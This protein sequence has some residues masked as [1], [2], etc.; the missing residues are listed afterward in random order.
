[1]LTLQKEYPNLYL[2]MTSTVS[3]AK[4]DQLREL[5]F[6]WPMDR[7]LLESTSPS[8]PHPDIVASMSRLAVGLPAQVQLIAEKVAAIKR[9]PVADVLA[10]TTTNLGR[11]YGMSC[12]SPTISASCG[13]LD[14][15]SAESHEDAQLPLMGKGEDRIDKYSSHPAKEAGASE[16]RKFRGKSQNNVDKGQS[17]GRRRR[18]Q[19]DPEPF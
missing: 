16:Q 3:F 15:S 11:L 7:L 9:M 8:N 10:L 5:A 6:D 2:G 12:F 19:G 14:L 18:G 17:G 1:M 13:P 4:Q